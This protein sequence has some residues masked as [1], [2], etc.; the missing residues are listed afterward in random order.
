[1]IKN[2]FISI[3][4]LITISSAGADENF[5]FCNNEADKQIKALDNSSD[6]SQ[7]VQLIEELKTKYNASL[8]EETVSA[9]VKTLNDKYLEKSDYSSALLLEMVVAMIANPS[10]NNFEQLCYGNEKKIQLCS[11]KG[12]KRKTI[13]ATFSNFKLACE[14]TVCAQNKEVKNINTEELANFIKARKNNVIVS[15]SIIAGLRPTASDALAES[16]ERKQ[17]RSQIEALQTDIFKDTERLKNFIG[18]KYIRSCSTSGTPSEIA[19]SCGASGIP[20]IMELKTAHETFRIIG[21]LSSQ[22]GESSTF[23]K[24]EIQSYK[25]ICDR[26]G[27]V[28]SFKATC[29]LVSQEFKKTQK[30]KEAQDWEAIRKHSYVEN[31]PTAPEGYRIIPKATNTEIFLGALAPAVANFAPFWMWNIQ[32]QAQIDITTQQ[33]IVQ[34]QYG[35]TDPTGYFQGNY[36]PMYTNTPSLSNIGFNFAQ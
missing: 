16:D 18:E 27:K 13:G 26:N 9:G 28:E 29:K 31:D 24:A 5:P 34:R 30:V 1:M 11:L 17:Y 22:Q 32:Q 15:P 12:D 7:V 3:L 21:S 10:A 35:Y 14:H 6:H 20:K 4:C 23:S 19:S 2:I 25:E 33:M 8:A 36:M